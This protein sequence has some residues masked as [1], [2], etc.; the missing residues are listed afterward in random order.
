MVREWGNRYHR[1]NRVRKNV[2]YSKYRKRK[3]KIWTIL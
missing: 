2:P 3:K 1:K